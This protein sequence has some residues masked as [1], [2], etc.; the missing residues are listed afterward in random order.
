MTQLVH[1]RILDL[2]DDDGMTYDRAFIYAAP[3]PRG[4][5]RAW[6]EFVSHDGEVVLRTGQETTQST[7]EAIAYWAT[8]LELV[9]FEGAFGRAGRRASAEVDLA[10]LADAEPPAIGPASRS[11]PVPITIETLD[12]EVPLLVMASRTVVPGMGR[13]IHSG[14]MLV[15]QGSKVS[16]AA[17]KPDVYEFVAQF[18][19]DNAAA[20]LA[21]TLWNELH[22]RAAVLRIDGLEVPIQNAAIKEALIAPVNA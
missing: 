5:W 20:L 10:D 14:G 8:G 7:L 3:Q 11:G 13:K 6:I 2:V 22:G 15:Y 16:R 4:T 18:G 17:D 9:Y 19:S 1:E 21:N 12:P